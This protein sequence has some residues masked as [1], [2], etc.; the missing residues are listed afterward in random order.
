MTRV[1]L[2]EFE[3]ILLLALAR[4]DEDASSLDVR[5]CIEARTGRAVSPGAIYTAFQRLER[6]GFVATELRRADASARRQAQEALS[7]APRRRPRAAGDAGCA[8]RARARAQTTGVF[9]MTTPPRPPRL[10]RLLARVLL[11]GEMR[12]IVLGDLDEEFALA[13]AAGIDRRQARRRYWRQAFAS[14]ASPWRG[15]SAAPAVS[16][17][18]PGRLSRAVQGVGLDVRHAARVLA[19]SPGFTL[20]AVAS[21]AIG[22][23]ANTAMYNVVRALLI[24]SLPVTRPDE[25]ALAYWTRPADT[26]IRML[27]LNSRYV[28]RS[29]IWPA[30]P[31]QPHV[32]DVRGHAGRLERVPPDLRLQ[33]HRPG[34]RVDRRAAADACR[35]HARDQ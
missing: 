1:H 15:A 34:Q 29:Q 27:E 13:I 35:W 20:V 18:D 12:E 4:L 30:A 23:G 33:L 6:R 8:R 31:E 5:G 7:P 2:G 24:E 16:T 22:I 25:L 21:L 14:I 11:R 19:R 10:P 3:Q 32:F 9:T 28:P 17:A 26:K